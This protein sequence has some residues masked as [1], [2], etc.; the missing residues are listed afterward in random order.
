MSFIQNLFTSR[1]N[2]ANSA[3]YVGQADRLWWDPVTNQFYYSDGNTAGGFPVGGGSG[4]ANP[5]GSNTQIQFNNNGSFGASVNLTFNNS[6]NTLAVTGAASVTGNV[7]A[8]YFVGNGSQLTGLPA[9]YSNAQVSAYLASGTNSANITTSANISG[10]YF[11]GNGSQLTG[12]NVSTNKIFNGNSYANVATPNGNVVINANGN[13]WTFDTDG[14]L[15][16]AYVGLVRRQDSVNIVSNGFAQLQWV[17]SGNINT[18]DP[19]G[20]AGPTNWAYVDPYGFHVE[21]NINYQAG[22]AAHSWSFDINGNLTSAGD[23]QLVTNNN[24][25]KFDASGNLTLPGNTSSINYANGTPYGNVTAGNVTIQNQGNTLTTAVNTINF[26]GNGVSSTNVGNVVTVNVTAGSGTL[27][28]QTGN[29]G[30]ILSTDGTNPL[31]ET[32][33]GVFGL[34]IDGGTAAYV[35]PDFIIDGG[36]AA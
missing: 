30:K 33:P 10:N 19:N 12:I 14:A 28:S 27:P 31:W 23:L 3:T 11:I 7:T 2:N 26:T 16:L 36:T 22:N 35:S 15:N 6:A 5:A 34:V 1:D 20:T 13:S 32:M 25:W 18:P 8:N 21:S 4:N 17:D 24:L 29:A 9:T